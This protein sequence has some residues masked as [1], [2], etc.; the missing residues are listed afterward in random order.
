MITLLNTH[1]LRTAKQSTVQ[2][3]LVHLM[4]LKVS[5]LL[6]I[7]HLTDLNVNILQLELTVSS[8]FNNLGSVVSDISTARFKVNSIIE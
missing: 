5:V 2:L 7:Y 8:Q 1:D 6:L 4:V 3:L